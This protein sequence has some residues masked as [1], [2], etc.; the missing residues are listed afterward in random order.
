MNLLIWPLQAIARQGRFVLIAGLLIGIL[1]P[2]LA[3]ALRPYIPQAAAL[4]LF[5]SALRIGLRQAVG[6]VRQMRVSLVAILAYQIGIPLLL[7]V[8]FKLAGLQGAIVS[9]LILITSAP[10][11]SGGPSLVALTGHDPSPALRVLIGG[12]ALLPLTILP[13]FALWPEFGSKEAVLFASLRLVF[14]IGGAAAASFAI[15]ALF[16]KNPTPSSIAAIDGL[17]A[18]TMALV[19]IGLMAGFGQTLLTQPGLIA[20]M[21]AVAFGLNF[22]LQVVV[23]GLF[24]LFGIEGNAEV[25]YAITSGNRNVMLF[26]AALPPSVTTPILLFVA[27]YQIP[28]YLTP[29]LLARLYRRV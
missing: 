16:L 13:V 19:V 11:I 14:M 26:I 8:V 23:F 29:L 10:T 18:L 4:M 9:A 22:G 21:L 27:C 15:R 1:V 3:N 20:V 24:R 25:A 12:T 2:A 17:A 5:V 6:D 7:T 28:M